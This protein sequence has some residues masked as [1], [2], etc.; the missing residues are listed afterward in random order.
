MRGRTAFLAP[1][2]PACFHPLCPDTPVGSSSLDMEGIVEAVACFAYTGRTA[3]ELSFQRGDVLRLHQR[4]S[5][6]WWRGEH[7]GT[8]G[9][10]PHKYIM[11]PAGCVISQ[12]PLPP[13]AYAQSLENGLH[14]KYLS[15]SPGLTSK[16]WGCR[17]W[18][19]HWSVLRGP[20]P[21]T[22]PLGELLGS[23]C[24]RGALLG[25]RMRGP[26]HLQPG[27]L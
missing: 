18:G 19:S 7:A 8:W 6:D 1:P 24:L 10:I 17:L 9:L 14:Q 21:W 25:G 15:P 11:L 3:Q 12:L 16:Q 27:L 5:D 4:A 13:H 2:L 22:P 23:G 20:W 26:A